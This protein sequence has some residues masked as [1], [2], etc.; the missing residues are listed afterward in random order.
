VGAAA[1]T[2]FPSLQTVVCPRVFCE[3]QSRCV[4]SFCMYPAFSYTKTTIYK[5]PL[6]LSLF[7]SYTQDISVERLHLRILLHPFPA[8]CA[9]RIFQAQA[10]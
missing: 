8:I 10:R 6:P 4:R 3:P 1:P 7:S 9:V 2:P 5:P